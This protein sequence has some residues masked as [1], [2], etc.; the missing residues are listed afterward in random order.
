MVQENCRIADLARPGEMT[1]ADFALIARLK[2][3]IAQSQRV[4]CTGCGYCQPCPPRRGY[5]EGCSA[6]R[7][8]IGVD[9]AKR[10]RREYLQTTAMRSPSTGAGQCVGCGKCEQHCPQAIPIR[11]ALQ[12]ARH[13]LETP[14][15]LLT[16]AA[17]RL[18]KI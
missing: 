13:D 14:L 10:A 3:A 12:E 7:N 4:G 6:A 16:A 9:G 1:E 15:Y 2:E 8:E 17:Y 18:L 5:P 11:Q